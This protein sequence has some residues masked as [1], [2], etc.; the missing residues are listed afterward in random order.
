MSKLRN[1]MAVT[2][3]SGLSALGFAQ[4]GRDVA[5]YP[6]TFTDGNKTSRQMVVLTAKRIAENQGLHVIAQD[7]AYG[8]FDSLR[9]KISLDKDLPAEPDLARFARAVHAGNLIFGHVSWHTRSKWVGTGPKTISSAKVDVYVFN[10]K[11]GK[12]TYSKEGIEAR[13]DEKES[14]LKDVAAILFTPII[15]MISGGPATPRE[16]RAVQIA[17]GKALLDWTKM[18]NR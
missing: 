16:Q 18:I 4:S 12:V 3:L 17:L 15:P 7:T 13:S 1:L 9:P 5:L 11:E 14:T 2:V 10:L 8:K 6:W